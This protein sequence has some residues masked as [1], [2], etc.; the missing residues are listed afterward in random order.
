MCFLKQVKWHQW[1]IQRDVPHLEE[2]RFLL[3]L[4]IFASSYQL[5]SGRKYNVIKREILKKEHPQLKWETHFFLPQLWEE[6]MIWRHKS[7]S[8][9]L[10]KNC[11]LIL[12]LCYHL[13]HQ[14]YVANPVGDYPFYIWNMFRKWKLF[15]FDRVS[16]IQIVIIPLNPLLLTQKDK[17]FLQQLK[18]F[19]FLLELPFLWRISYLCNLYTTGRVSG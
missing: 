12:Q 7:G 19:A 5:P 8:I 13:K 14:W 10:W 17:F 4:H 2:T 3:F 16:F 6:V 11:R 18:V 15:D 1:E 9:L